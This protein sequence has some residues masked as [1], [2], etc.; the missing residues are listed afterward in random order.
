MRT[1]GEGEGMM[2]NKEAIKMLTA[3]AECIRRE[4]SG[5]DIDCNLRNCDECDLCYKQGTMGEQ[6]EA[7]G[8][9][10]SALQARPEIIRCKDCVY[11]DTSWQNNFAAN[12]HYCPLA[13]GVRKGDFYCADAERRG[14]D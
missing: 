14:D 5:T 6:M 13:D 10:I 2:T 11:W 4:T 9:A 7:L 8:M 12:Y 3:K 1:L